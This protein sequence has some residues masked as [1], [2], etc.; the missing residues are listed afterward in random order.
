MLPSYILTTNHSPSTHHRHCQPC[1]HH[2]ITSSKNC[3]GVKCVQKQPS[4]FHNVYT[5]H[6]L[7]LQLV[8][9]AEQTIEKT[10]EP[11]RSKPIGSAISV[12]ASVR[13]IIYIRFSDQLS[14]VKLPIETDRKIELLFSSDPL[15][16]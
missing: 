9:R 7:Y 16:H 1:G 11:N 13:F 8:V 5:I 10:E 15:T 3:Q 2:G 12:I 14:V 6:I 4:Q